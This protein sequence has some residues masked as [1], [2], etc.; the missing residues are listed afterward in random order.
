M[1]LLLLLASFH[2]TISHCDEEPVKEE[3]R[4]TVP[5]HPETHKNNQPD[6]S[7]NHRQSEIDP[8]IQDIFHEGKVHAS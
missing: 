5:Q 8:R 6:T 3:Q 7:G 2:F 1:V 4:V